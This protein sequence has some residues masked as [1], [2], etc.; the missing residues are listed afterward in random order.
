MPTTFLD[1]PSDIT[2]QIFSH[3]ER[4]V[5]IQQHGRISA[6]WDGLVTIQACRLTCRGLNELVSGMLCPL[7]RGRLD[8]TTM[9]RIEKLSLNPLIADGIRVVELNLS[10]RPKP[11]ASD[12][13]VYCKFVTEKVDDFR[14]SCHYHTEFQHY[15][16]DDESAEALEHRALLEAEGRLYLV[17]ES[18]RQ[19]VEPG[20]A[21]R[22]PDAEY[23]QL[24]QDCF[25]TYAS[26]QREEEEI[27]ND[28]SFVR[29]VA[30]AM[31]RCKKAAQ[32]SFGDVSDACPRTD[33][34]KVANDKDLLA[35]EM[36][37]PHDWLAVENGVEGAE[38]LPARLLAELPIACARLGAPLRGLDV[39]CFPLKTM[40]S[41][42]VP[43]ES[44]AT[45]LQAELAAA[46]RGLKTF[47]FGRRGM[48]CTPYRQQRLSAEN[49][50]LVDAYLG[51]VCSSP[52]LAFVYISM[53]PFRMCGTQTYRGPVSPDLHYQGSAVVRS[54]NSPSL[55]NIEINHIEVSGSDLTALLG[56]LPSFRMRNIRLYSITLNEG[57]FTDAVEVLRRIKTDSPS[58]V[59]DVFGLKG[60][61][62]GASEGFDEKGQLI[63]GD[64]DAEA[65]LER[66]DAHTH[67][68]LLRRALAYVCG[69]SEVN[70][71]LVQGTVG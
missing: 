52:E 25:A 9:E 69:E 50:A 57:G 16:D 33:A 38:L 26:K 30:R 24:L 14:G 63:F 53:C 66:L 37:L 49:C 7:F 36:L 44:T 27:V 55:T 42:L 1:L 64:E 17:R 61:E 28:G 39:G 22:V 43:P 45:I 20:K 19:V 34:V 23:Q 65:F 5:D 31:A 8:K 4:D 54:F 12:I 62:F 41:S 48:H 47:L 6:Q 35:R 68:P 67:P 21:H 56:S 59:V 40:F 13:G 32:L 11:I 70:P 58:C 46:C 15:E 10:F 60:G 2:S 51:A 71:L 3:F 29:T 18:W